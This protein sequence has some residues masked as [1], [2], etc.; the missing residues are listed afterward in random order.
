MTVNEIKAALKLLLSKADFTAAMNTLTAWVQGKY[1]TLLGK[2][3]ENVVS[4]SAKSSATNGSVASYE[5]KNSKST[6]DV[7]GTIEIP[8]DLSDYDNT[9]SDFQSGDQVDA[10]V[11]A[12]IGAVHRPSGNIAP[13]DL[14]AGLLV[15]ANLGKVFNLTGD[16][17]TDSN[18]VEGSGNLVKAGSDVSIVEADVYTASEDTEVDSEKTY[19]SDQN[20][21]EVDLTADGNAEKDP[22]EQGWF[23]RGTT[24]KFNATGLMID[25]TAYVQFT[26]FETIGTTEAVSIVNAAITAAETPAQQGE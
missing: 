9:T 18:W 10:K 2:I 7:L 17:Q 3:N 21:T 5:L 6:P 4:I 8:A 25:L 14:V 11:A 26:D 16:K 24:Y 15:K 22:S 1:T 20:G 19:Y 23:E 13:A 12:A